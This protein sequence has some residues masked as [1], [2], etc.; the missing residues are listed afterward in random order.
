MK[1]T[2]PSPIPTP[3]QHCEGLPTP[4][5][6]LMSESHWMST[7]L[8]VVRH[9]GHCKFNGFRYII[10]DEKGRDLWEC[11]AAATREGRSMAIEPGAPADLI[12][13]DLQPHY[14]RLGRNR[15]LTLLREGKTFDEIARTE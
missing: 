11:S 7:Q 15:I 13:V 2:P 12:C 4:T 1:H 3:A 8:S 6:L 10:V 9:F 14:R 5:I